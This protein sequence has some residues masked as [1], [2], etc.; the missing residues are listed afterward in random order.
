[1]QPGASPRPSSKSP[2][3][4]HATTPV[5][6]SPC[7]VSVSPGTWSASSTPEPSPKRE[8][9]KR[10]P[11]KEPAATPVTKI[12][13]KKPSNREWKSISRF[14]AGPAQQTPTVGTDAPPAK[15]TKPKVQRKSSKKRAKTAVEPPPPD[16]KAGGAGKAAKKTGRVGK[17][18]AATTGDTVASARANSAEA[19]KTL[20][21]VLAAS[22]GLGTFQA[23]NLAAQ[24]LAHAKVTSPEVAK[25][26]FSGAGD[27]KVALQPAPGET[28]EATPTTPA[29]PSIATLP[30]TAVAPAS[31]PRTPQTD[32]MLPAI[33]PVVPA[34]AGPHTAHLLET[35]L[36]QQSGGQPFHPCGGFGGFGQSGL[37]VGQP[38]GLGGG[39]GGAPPALQRLQRQLQLA[40]HP[41]NSL[42][43][44]YSPP[45]NSLN[46]WCHFR[47]EPHLET[48]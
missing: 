26:L 32:I 35:L 46:L 44:K 33:M 24:W 8:K 38:L 1:M 19:R 47:S 7:V 34:A 31:D 22:H 2:V 45:R 20:G 28:P 43:Q 27:E 16:E 42:C 18:K 4:K 14:V 30:G 17:A 23:A 6:S 9:R 15:Q 21:K 40:R 3:R 25:A 11:A 36:A 37:G 10:E 5:Y 13:A 29:V 48:A 41:S 12:P 39:L